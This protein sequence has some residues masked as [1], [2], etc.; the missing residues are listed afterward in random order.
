MWVDAAMLETIQSF[1]FWGFFVSRAGDLMLAVSLVAALTWAGYGLSRRWRVASVGIVAL[2][3][4]LKVVGAILVTVAYNMT[5]QTYYGLSP[6]FGEL[7]RMFEFGMSVFILPTLPEPKVVI[8][9]YVY[10]PVVMLAGLA[11][12][13]TGLL[14]RRRRMRGREAPAPA[15]PVD[16]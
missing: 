13:S 15:V 10:L 8:P 12:W 2:M 7:L 9:I 4:V 3:V 16:A 1:Q 6:G 11:A 14:L 5:S